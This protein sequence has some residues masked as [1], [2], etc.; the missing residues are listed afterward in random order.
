[1]CKQLFS[2]II[3]F[4]YYVGVRTQGSLIDVSVIEG[5]DCTDTFYEL[6]ILCGCHGDEKRQNLLDDEMNTRFVAYVLYETNT[7]QVSTEP[8]WVDGINIWSLSWDQDEKCKQM[9]IETPH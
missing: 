3:Q 5:W 8:R 1:M 9:I 6:D 4:V 7:T 2:P